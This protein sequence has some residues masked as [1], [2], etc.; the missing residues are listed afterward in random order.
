MKKFIYHKIFKTLTY[1]EKQDKI[2]KKL[3]AIYDNYKDDDFTRKEFEE[4]MDK[5]SK[6]DED[7][8]DYLENDG[9]NDHYTKKRNKL[10]NDYIDKRDEENKN[11]KK[12]VESKTIYVPTYY[13]SLESVRI[14]EQNA[15]EEKK[16]AEASRE[17]PELLGKIQT[18]FSSKL[19]ERIS[20][21]KKKI[22]EELNNYSPINLKIFLQNLAENEKIKDKLIK[23][24]EMESE[25]ILNKTYKN[26][27]HFN[28]LLIGKTGVGKS[29]L[30]NGIFDFNENEGA[31]TGDGKPITKEFGEFLSDKRKGLRIIDSK[32]IEM[33][34][35]NINTVFDLTKELI[36]KRAVEGDP[37]KLIH[38]IWYCFKSSN[39]RFE[40][41]EKDTVSLLMNQY[42]DN[43]LPIVIV[44]TQNYDDEATKTM[45]D[46]IKDEFKFLN[47]EMTIMPVIAKNKIIVK[48]NNQ[49]VFEKDGIE[50]LIKISFEKSR[51]A[52]YP[53]FKK[54]IEKQIIQTFAIHTE[55]KKNKL[56]DDLKEIL[57]KI[58]NEISE[59]EDME[60]NISNLSLIIEKTLNI[61][62][63]IL[64]ISEKSKKDINEFLDNLCK[65]C[66]ER[67]NNI[68]SDLVKENTNELSLLLFNEQEKVK[69]YHNVQRNL[70]NEKTF[71]EFKILSE[72]DL[73]PSITNKV[74]FL[75]I[76]DIYNIISEKIVEMSEEVLKEQF[77]KIMPELRNNISD[78][79][80]KQLSNKILQD[81]V[82]N[83]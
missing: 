65:W 59:N 63:E 29:T 20:R 80:L 23:D 54:S 18:D 16:R 44:I 50:E 64:V 22:K 76:K 48:K 68:I 25:K 7:V 3:K 55:N 19:T 11:I 67:L 40:N 8:K 36:E 51:K 71:D 38:C 58:L 56:K 17:L 53:A 35:H 12:K 49:F 10:I 21:I 43:N 83:N 70:Y 2:D 57:K 37:D 74:Y 81:I 61:Y 26:S 66:I 79:K 52:I 15:L 4:K 75:A 42:D 24:S 45:T 9:L 73:K 47:R 5:E 41:I 82:K 46:Y 62:F 34:E 39:L 27:N 69:K 14:R 77:N 72:A 32:G 6:E 33:G 31:K 28:V 1:E 78:E 13:E 60:N 30:I